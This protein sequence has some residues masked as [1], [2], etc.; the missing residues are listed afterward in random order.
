MTRFDTTRWSMVL[1]ARKEPE[2]A[3]RALETLCRSY[4]PPV[5]AY[6]R[7]HGYA[8]DSAEDLT[9]A[10]FA[11]FVEQAYHRNADPE[12]GR[13]R[14]YLLTALKRFLLDADDQAH[15]V[16]R[17]GRVQVR[18]LETLT[19]VGDTGG[20]GIP[21]ERTPDRAFQRAWAHQ[22]IRTAMRQLRAE[23]KAAGKLELFESLSE[24]LA[25]RPDDADYARVAAALNLRRNTLAVAV[26]RLRSRLREL[27][28]EQLADT[29]SS[30]EEMQRELH[31]LQHSLDA[32]MG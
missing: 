20:N 17:G 30:A 10:F 15:A 9:Q 11:R 7:S 6:I 27:V 8:S 24:F 18:S 31:E 4:R 22:V 14:A 2:Q 3:R 25:E 13:F 29:A 23:A 16:K 21:D 19:G 26:H 5:L 32:A 28:R 12:R 1:E